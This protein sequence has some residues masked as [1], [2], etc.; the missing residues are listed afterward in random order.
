MKR[1]VYQRIACL[2]EAIENCRKAGN[3]EWLE[4]HSEA[5]A[6][7]VENTMPS[8]SG[9]DSGT[10]LLDESTSSRLVFQVDF[11]HMNDNGMYDGWSDHTVIV[12][13]S[14]AFGFNLRVTGRD[15]QGIKEYLAETYQFALNQ[16]TEG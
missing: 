13:P 1:P 11:H 15:R 12:T 7:L 10:K 9:I 6:V 14:L 4:K 3:Q 2:L 8:G 16:E 5:L